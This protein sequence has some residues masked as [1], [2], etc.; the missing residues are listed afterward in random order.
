MKCF[1]IVLVL[2]ACG[3]GGD[4]ECVTIADCPNGTPC[5]TATCTAGACG[6]EIAPAGD[7]EMQTFDDCK[8]EVCDGAG[9]V[10]LVNDD[11]DHG[12]SAEC[13]ITGCQ[14][15]V[16]VV[17]PLTARAEC[18]AGLCDGEGTCVECLDAGDCFQSASCSASA[19]DPVDCSA[20]ATTHLLISEMR[21]RGSAGQNDDLVE[22]YNPTDSPITLGP[23]VAL[24]FRANTAAVYS[25]HW[26]GGNQ[27]IPAHGHFLIGGTGYND[28]VAADAT[29]LVGI[30]D[31][32]S[33]VLK[34]NGLAI[35][36]L[37]Y[38]A[39]G[40]QLDNTF[41][42]DGTPITRENITTPQDKSVHR[43]P[44]GALGNCVDHTDTVFDWIISTDSAPQNLAAAATP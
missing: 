17:A 36:A 41:V 31:Q 39:A 16:L 21:A 22:L 43:K 19:C 32:G 26:S 13:S 10:T 24:E 9:N 37:C 11:A 42:C 28:A 12:G 7:A 23:A 20:S 35:D 33:L 18:T 14:D 29:L 2:G 40:T 1:T 25:T 27:V 30:G 6:F 5:L 44:D 3:G 4:D 8:R 15:G 34:Q 38:V